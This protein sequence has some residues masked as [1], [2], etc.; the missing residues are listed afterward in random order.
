MFPAWLDWFSAPGLSGTRAVEQWTGL[1]YLGSIPKA[2]LPP[3]ERNPAQAVVEEDDPPLAAAFRDLHARLLAAHPQAKVVAVASALPNDAKTTCAV[4]LARQSALRGFR[5]ALVDCDL[6]RRSATVELDHPP[7]VGLLEVMAGESTL[8]TA[9]VLDGFTT[10]QVLPVADNSANIQRAVVRDIFASSEME[11]LISLLRQ[12][13]EYV[14]IDTP[15]VL[16]VVDAR[17]L[18]P[19]VDT[20]L[21]VTR[22]RRTPRRAV[23]MAVAMLNGAGATLAGLVLTRA[24]LG[25]P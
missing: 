11:M 22:W 8:E 5:T 3:G 19:L 25:A 23:K 6:R 2:Q 24:P 15:P 1:P 14:F 9:L 16:A 4:A 13:F 7:L 10:L 12:R 20:F 21:F 18:A 17:R